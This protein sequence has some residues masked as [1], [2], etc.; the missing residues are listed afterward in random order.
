[1]LTKIQEAACG[2]R[3]AQALAQTK[4]AE[5]D[6]KDVASNMVF[7]R[8]PGHQAEKVV[9]ALE[10]QGIRS[11]A[12]GPDQVRFVTHLDVSREDTKEVARIVGAL[13]L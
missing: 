9:Q 8:A 10:K 5:V 13:R 1:M 2:F 7:F 11:G 3:G 12:T 6:P 4:W